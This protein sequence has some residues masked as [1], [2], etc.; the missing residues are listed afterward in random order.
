MFGLTTG[1]FL[2]DKRNNTVYSDQL[3]V[4]IPAP[5]GSFLWVDAQS[6]SAEEARD[7]IATGYLADA[8]NYLSKEEKS[9][10]LGEDTTET[11]ETDKAKVVNCSSISGIKV[12]GKAL[13]LDIG[14]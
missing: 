13:T 3:G 10:L 12:N 2:I 7:L 9:K 5:K 14:G 11:E 6:V 8:L 1:R 4:F